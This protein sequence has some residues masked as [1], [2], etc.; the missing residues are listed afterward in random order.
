MW[1]GVVWC[2]AVWCGVVWCGVV[3]CGVVWC[4]AVWC[5]VVWC[6]VVWCGVVWCVWCVVWFGVVRCAEGAVTRMQW[7]GCLPTGTG[8]W[9]GRVPKCALCASVLLYSRDQCTVALG[10]CCSADTCA[11]SQEA[12]GSGTPSMH[13]HTA[14][15]QWAVELLQ[16]TASVPGGSGQWNCCNALPH[17]PRAVG[18]GTAA[19]HRPTRSGA[20]LKSWP[21]CVSAL[22][23]L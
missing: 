2:G 4:G 17:Y 7:P 5:G 3:W 18:S 19:M 13:C 16:C 10:Q 20:S 6:G 12:V 15:G 1:C 21:P 22:G 11:R 8:K 14:R 9:E 23:P